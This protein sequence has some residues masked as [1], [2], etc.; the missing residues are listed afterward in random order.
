MLDFKMGKEW[1]RRNSIKKFF[2]VIERLDQTWWFQRILI[3]FGRN[4]DLFPNHFR[5]RNFLFLVT[6]DPKVDKYMT[7]KFLFPEFLTRFQKLNGIFM[8]N[9]FRPNIFDVFRIEF[10]YFWKCTWCKVLKN[11]WEKRLAWPSKLHN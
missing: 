3:N 11:F 9:K 4:F 8:R 7:E 2:L 1:R 10:E 5:S 6:L